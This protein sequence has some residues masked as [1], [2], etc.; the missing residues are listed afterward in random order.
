MLE[1]TLRLLKTVVKR[2]PSFNIPP[3]DPDPM[4][5]FST[6]NRRSDNNFTS[7]ASRT[8]VG[9]P[10]S[11]ALLLQIC[12]PTLKREHGTPSRSVKRTRFEQVGSPTRSKQP[13]SIPQLEISHSLRHRR[14]GEISKRRSFDTVAACKRSNEI[15]DIFRNGKSTFNMLGIPT[16][17]C[18]STESFCQ[19]MGCS[20][21]T[22]C[23]PQSR[24]VLELSTASNRNGTPCASAN[25]GVECDLD[26]AERV[27]PHYWVRLFPVHGS[28]SKETFVI[29]T[30]SAPVSSAASGKADKRDLRRSGGSIGAVNRFGWP[31]GTFRRRGETESVAPRRNEKSVTE[32]KPSRSRASFEADLSPIIEDINPFN[33]QSGFVDSTLDM[34]NSGN[35]DQSMTSELQEQ[36]DSR[37]FDRMNLSGSFVLQSTSCLD[38]RGILSVAK[39]NECSR[40]IGLAEDVLAEEEE[41]AL[42]SVVLT[43]PTPEQPNSPIFTPQSPFTLHKFVAAAESGSTS[44]RGDQTHSSLAV[45]AL[46]RCTNCGFGFGLDLAPVSTEP[47]RLCEPQ[48]LACKMWYEARGDKLREPTAVRPAESNANSRAIISKL[49]LPVGSYRGLGIRV[50][51]ELGQLGEEQAQVHAEAAS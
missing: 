42:P 29:C 28:R 15:W 17:H 6:G 4:H 22:G 20:N 12:T 18:Y 40:R 36:H 2:K 50:V 31:L 33:S 51:D 5:N 43:F 32:S 38:M 13:G 44:G 1:N 49:G 41:P 16:Q 46:P 24:Q 47:C 23:S 7:S 48:W 9:S 10:V 3:S 19:I 26:A 45:P 11:V 21:A 35:I 27:W 34:R 14:M 37:N 25:G 30:S 39:V 8:T